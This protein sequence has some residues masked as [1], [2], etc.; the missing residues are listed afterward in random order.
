[1]K[2][3]SLSIIIMFYFYAFSS[4]NL[5]LNEKKV[6]HNEWNTF[7]ILFLSRSYASTSVSVVSSTLGFLLS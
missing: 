4:N 7:F 3:C 1:M 6:L 2:K 5:D